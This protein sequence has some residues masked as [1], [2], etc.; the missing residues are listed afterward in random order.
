MQYF[1]S[2]YYY[3][4]I[5]KEQNAPFLQF[6]DFKKSLSMNRMWL[7]G[8]NNVLS[9]SIP[10][11]GG[12]NNKLSFGDVM[13]ADDRS[14]KRVHW[15]TIHDSYRKSP[16][17]DQYGDSL[18]GLYN[19]QV[20]IL[21]QWNYECIKWALGQIKEIDVKMSVH[22]S[23]NETAPISFGSG[24]PLL[25]VPD[26][27]PRYQQVFSDRHGFVANL[28]ILD[29]LFNVGPD[30]YSY[31]IQLSSYKSCALDNNEQQKT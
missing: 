14:W 1:G 8:P 24:N 11:E 31:L 29:L 2:I 23:V 4:N 7:M 5:I 12:R 6:T 30:A 18:N 15:R 25:Q 3:L 20:R 21:W 16:W 28:S 19:Q 13:I 17:F 26:S 27:Y 22:D 9:L 10:L